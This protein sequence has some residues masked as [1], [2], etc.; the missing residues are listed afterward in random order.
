MIKFPLTNSEIKDVAEKLKKLQPGFLPFDIFYQF[1]RL[2]VTIT[3]EV[4]PLCLDPSGEV[5]VVLFNRGPKDPWWPNLY[6]TPGACVIDGDISDQD[7]W[8]LPTKTFTRLKKDE[9]KDIQLINSPQFVG[10]LS[11]QTVRGPES[12]HVYI[13]EVEYE[14][15]KPYLFPVSQLPKNIVSHQINMIKK[16][17]EVYK[18]SKTK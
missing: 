16:C 8:G 18:L 9:F 13:Q 2:K 14:S 15:A 11:H 4:V 5:M 1:N 6:H 17:A 3:I 12:V 10:N 7:E